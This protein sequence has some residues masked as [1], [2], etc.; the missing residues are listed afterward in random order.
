MS[1][2]LLVGAYL[3]VGL[4][5][6]L[7]ELRGVQS[8]AARD[9]AAFAFPLLLWPLW[10]PSALPP[11]A[12]RRRRARGSQASPLGKAIALLWP[13]RV[14]IAGTDQRPSS[15]RPFLRAVALLTALGLF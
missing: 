15:R 3:I 9:L 10:A 2:T 11:R 12:G 5:C 4:V 6:A 7:F 14:T 13:A 1:S 8:R